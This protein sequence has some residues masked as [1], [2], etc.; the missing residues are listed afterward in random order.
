M[1]SRE[2][3]DSSLNYRQAIDV[4]FEQFDEATAANIITDVMKYTYTSSNLVEGISAKAEIIFYNIPYY[5]AVRSSLYPDYNTLITQI[6][7]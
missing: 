4:M 6:Y 1:Y 5:Y 7:N 2:V 3:Q